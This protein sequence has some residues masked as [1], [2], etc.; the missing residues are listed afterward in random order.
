MRGRERALLS[1]AFAAA[2]AL[3]SWSAGKHIL[4]DEA[5][6]RRDQKKLGRSPVPVVAALDVLNPAGDGRGS[7]PGLRPA[8][9][10]VSV[11]AAG[12]VFYKIQHLR[13]G[14]RSRCPHP[15]AGTTSGRGSLGYLSC[16]GP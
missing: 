11:A 6:P 16:S 7:S 4:L 1:G 12:L 5:A 10:R 9:G 15:E 14:A 13:T 8:R 3:S 2:C